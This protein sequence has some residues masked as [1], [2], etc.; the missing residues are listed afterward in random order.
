MLIEARINDS[1]SDPIQFFSSL[2]FLIEHHD[3][4]FSL[5]GDRTENEDEEATVTK[6]E[7]RNAIAY[8]V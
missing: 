1:S 2:S 8:H 7:I 6:I 4:F 5:I 3:K